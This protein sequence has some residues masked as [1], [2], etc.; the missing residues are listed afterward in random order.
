MSLAVGH[1]KEEKKVARRDP[2]SELVLWVGC[3]TCCKGLVSN[4]GW[5][6]QRS[7]VYPFYWR[8]WS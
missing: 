2:A 3:S 7:W 8:Y 6:L 5:C 4:L 1:N